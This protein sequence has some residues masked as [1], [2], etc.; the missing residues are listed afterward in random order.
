MRDQIHCNDVARL[1]LEF[2]RSPRCGE[3]YNLGGGRQNSIS[4]LETIDLL[5]AMGLR[6]RHKYDPEN[7]LGDHICYITDLGKVRSHFPNW[8]LKYNI[9]QIIAEIAEARSTSKP[10]GIETLAANERQ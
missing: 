6:V 2:F 5:A 8:E 3:V 4:I 9:F 7:R 10:H 1:L